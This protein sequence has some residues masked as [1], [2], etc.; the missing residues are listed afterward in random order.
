M[1]EQKSMSQVAKDFLKNALDKD[2]NSCPGIGKA[3]IEKLK[4]VGVTT[5]D[6]LVGQFFLCNRDEVK[7]IEFLEDVG[8]QNKYARECAEKFNAKF[9]G[10]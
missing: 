1:A 9:F 10:L 2:L 8:I 6:Q 4:K 7:F 5:T 3:S